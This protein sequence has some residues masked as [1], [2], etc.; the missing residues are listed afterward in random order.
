M[1][2]CIP[3]PCLPVAS[4]FHQPLVTTGQQKHPSTQRGCKQVHKMY[5]IFAIHAPAR[6]QVF[7]G[8]SE[9]AGFRLKFPTDFRTSPEKPWFFFQKHGDHHCSSPAHHTPPMLS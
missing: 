3:A 6:R 4:S 9:G 7:L 5:F 8:G 2:L 1:H